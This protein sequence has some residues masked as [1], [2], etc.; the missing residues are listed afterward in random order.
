MP[1]VKING[2]DVY[3]EV[4]GEGDTIILLH[5]GFGCVKIWKDVYPV[6]LEQGYRVVMYDRRGYGE[7]ENGPGFK[8]FFL[9]GRYRSESVKELAGLCE[10]LNL[11]TF[12][13][14]GQ[15]EGGVVGVDYAANY[16]D[17]VK[18]LVVASTLCYSQK[19]MVELNRLAF[20]KKFQDVDPD[21]KLKMIYW[22]GEEHAESFFNMCRNYGGAY[23]K[24]I[25]EIRDVLSSV[26]CPALVLY[27]DRSALFP[28]EQA[29]AFYRGLPQGELAVI[30]K[31]GHNTYEQQPREYNRLI[32]NFLNRYYFGS[33][34]GIHLSTCA[35]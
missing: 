7:S 35:Q 12:H 34:K 14:I 18:T 1:K 9:G 25:F 13:L 33:P 20:P 5:H 8:E 15:C 24:G 6:L 28:V 26:E 11:G 2:L 3:Y 4:H 16:P 31:C 23:G 19:P 30:P 22:H 17:Q 29:V 27:P 21:I 10:A 32:L